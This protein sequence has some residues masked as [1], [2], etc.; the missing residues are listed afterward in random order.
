LPK[1][2]QRPGA[3]HPPKI[4]GVLLCAG[5]LLAT[6]RCNSTV[7][8]ESPVAELTLRVGVGQAAAGSPLAGLRPFFQNLSGEGLARIGE[9]GKSEPRLAEGWAVARDGLSM[10]IRLRS[11]VTFHDGSPVTADAVV[12]VLNSGLP[13]FMGPPFSDVDRITAV[14]DYRIAIAFKRA[15][16]FLQ[17]ALDLPI[18]K[19]DSPSIGTGPFQTIDANSLNELHANSQYYL[20][21]PTIDRIVVTNYPSVRAAWADLLRDRIDM[22]YEVSADALDS[23]TGA[24]T[25]AVFSFTRPYQYVIAFNQRSPAIRSPNI[26]RALNAAI[27][28]AALVRD[29]LDGR[30]EPS[31]G[32]IWP[33][34]WA[35][36][37]D[38][39]RFKFDPQE[40]AMELSRHSKRQGPGP[41]D[42]VLR[43]KCLVQ[44]NQERL[45]LLVKRQ[46]EMVGVEMEIEEVSP[47]RMQQALSDS[48]FEAVFLDMVSGPS[49]FRTY[50][51]WHSAGS[52]NPGTL[53]GGAIDAAL[54][55]IRYASSDDEYRDAVAGFQRAVVDN[56]PGIFLAWSERARAVNRRF[57][58][59]AEP[60]RDILTTLR[61]WR[62]TNG[63]QSVSRN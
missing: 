12:K 47:D 57:D 2:E 58:V 36:T 18:R 61:L 35:F 44:N 59:A 39:Q 43:F 24:T 56:P 40:A 28:R 8:E 3:E 19:P 11:G 60:G 17:E 55:R 51:W 32:P 4:V 14:S 9:T 7:P 54:D 63:L 10:E 5:L 46:L 22:L 23:L 26:R 21:R 20:G 42:V 45:A 48:T 37:A 29:G 16:P 31:S 62:P 53:G 6:A 13:E 33:Q 38:L 34:H 25:V 50:Q 1:A 27:D 41:N 30:G 49:L 52:F 15:S